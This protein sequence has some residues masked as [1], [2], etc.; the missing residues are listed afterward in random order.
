[1]YIHDHFTLMLSRGAI[2]H[3]V[4]HVVRATVAYM[5]MCVIVEKSGNIVLNRSITVALT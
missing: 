4:V 2:V 1:M 3:E 5:Q